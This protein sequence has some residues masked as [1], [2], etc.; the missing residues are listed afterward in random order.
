MSPAL[1]QVAV[2]KYHRLSGLN[3]N[4]FLSS[5]GWEV[6]DQDASKAS[7]LGNI[8]LHDRSHT[9]SLCA[10][11]ECASELSGISSYKDAN[12]IMGPHPQDL[13]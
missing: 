8:S 2:T 11:R 12:P 13:S 10:Q 3:R 1:A 4:L 5:G 9:S 6:Q 7:H